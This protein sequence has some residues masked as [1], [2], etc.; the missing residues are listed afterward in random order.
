MQN[1]Q[2][3]LF[4]PSLCLTHNCNLD[5]IYCYQKHSSNARMSFETA[6]K[7]IN[8][9]FNNI[10]KDTNKIEINFIGGEP[11]LEF[12]LI[13]QI[14]EYTKSQNPK[15][16]YTFFAST[17]GTLLTYD[18]KKWFTTY[19]DLFCL[20]LSL[21]GIREVH[22]YNRSNS[23]DFID[24]D[25]FIKTWPQQGVKMTLSEFS[26]ENLA[27]NI[28]YIHSLG[29]KEIGG[30]NLF[31]G[32]FDWSNEK[33]IKALIPQL[34]KLVDFYL[35]ND[36]LPLN[37][38]FNKKLNLCESK[39]KFKR[40]YC[41]VGTGTIFFDVDGTQYPC[42][43]ITPMTFSKNEL[44]NIMKTDFKDAINFIDEECF[45]NCYIYQLC[46]NCS[47]A[48]YMANKT[49]KIR[50]K[51]KCKIQK[52]ICLFVADLQAKRIIKNPNKYD[53]TYLYYTIEAIKK[54]KQLYYPEF[55]GLV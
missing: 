15:V 7:S 19:K 51:S 1:K 20:G 42:S 55:S 52:L 18:I 12:N 9:I 13:K 39:E 43:F 6:K 10:P 11:L 50:N 40:K 2:Q 14:F 38:M 45:N 22:N 33:Y 17:N 25:F 28:I 47:G 23:F 35:E 8:W 27:E 32:N 53:K 41:G 5:C 34:K 46:P 16:N 21:D 24:I 30:V 4:S 36:T 31:E 37:Q 26:L 48:N 3:L 49:F 54:I 29:I 44:N